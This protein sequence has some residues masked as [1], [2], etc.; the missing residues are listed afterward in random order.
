MQPQRLKEPRQWIPLS[1]A[2]RILQVN[3]STVRQW[4]DTG[5]IRAFRTPGGHRRFFQEDVY[6]LLETGT[7]IG[8]GQALEEQALRRIR[9][10]LRA[11]RPGAHPWLEGVEESSRTRMRL[12]GRRLVT[13]VLDYLGSPRRRQERLVEA[14]LIGREQG[15]EMAR[16]GFSLREVVEGFLFFRNSLMDTAMGA[17]PRATEPLTFWHQMNVVVDE[18]LLG[19]IEAFHPEP[20]EALHNSPIPVM[21]R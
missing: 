3:E 17:S 7:R 10:R 1:A 20:Q 2:C 5:R 13:V 4:A 16:L 6:A 21:E 19:V 11:G 12:F 15:A 9:R 18:V 14:R 8:D